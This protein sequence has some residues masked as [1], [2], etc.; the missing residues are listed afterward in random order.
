MCLILLRV[1]GYNVYDCDSSA[2]AIVDSSENIKNKI[3]D[4][5]GAGII[6]SKGVLDRKRL[7]DI[8]FADKLKLEKLNSIVHKAVI[9]DLK[10]KIQTHSSEFVCSCGDVELASPSS[11]F[12]FETAI[13]YESGLDKLCTQVWWVTAPESLRI[14]RVMTRNNISAEAV[15]A[16]MARQIDEPDSSEGLVRI[17]NDSEHALIPQIVSCLRSGIR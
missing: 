2:K 10:S 13:L 5:F 3:A 14:Q 9:D 12:F 7:G 8:V 15:R 1:M 4:T 6:D 17:L 16:R 11:V